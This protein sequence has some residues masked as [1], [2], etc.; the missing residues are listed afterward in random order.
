MI[1]PLS[2]VHVSATGLGDGFD[3]LVRA[4]LDRRPGDGCFIIGVTGAVASGK[5]TL[6]TTLRERLSAWP[7][8]PVVSWPAPTVSCIRTPS[9]KCWA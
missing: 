8:R 6:S 1:D 4:L 3:A 2:D 9:S 7:G 5:S